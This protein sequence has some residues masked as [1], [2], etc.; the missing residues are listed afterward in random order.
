MT[1]FLLERSLGVSV[2][3]GAGL[4]GVGVR[5]VAQKDFWQAF[6]DVEE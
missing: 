1:G 4:G 3:D 2:K 5:L 6:N